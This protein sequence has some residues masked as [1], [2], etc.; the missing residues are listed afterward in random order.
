VDICWRL[1]QAA[2]KSGSV[3]RVVWHF[4]PLHLAGL[5]ETATR[6]WEAEALLVRKHPEY[7]NSVGGN[8]WRGRIYTHLN[9]AYWSGRQSFT[10][11]S[12]AARASSFFTHP[13]PPCH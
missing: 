3:Q 2:T 6:I 13:N 10:A 8:I 1:Q 11:A 9:S 7:F 12:L 4:S 5:S